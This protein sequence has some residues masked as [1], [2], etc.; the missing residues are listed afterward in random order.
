MTYIAFK[1]K[2]NVP[3]NT[4]LTLIF[5]LLL[6]LSI[7]IKREVERA[8]IGDEEDEKNNKVRSLCVSI[9]RSS[10]ENYYITSQNLRV[11]K[12]VSDENPFMLKATKNIAHTKFKSHS[13]RPKK[14]FQIVYHRFHKF[15]FLKK[16]RRIYLPS[17]HLHYINHCVISL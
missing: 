2:R 13:V 17:N 14:W 4:K 16:R 11:I 8:W 6:I 5:T 15:F 7:N 9:M 12:S 3:A 10:E 1:K